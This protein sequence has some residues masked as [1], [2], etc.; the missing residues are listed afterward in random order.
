MLN[1]TLNSSLNNVSS[2]N[3]PH[4]NK[5]SVQHSIWA[6]FDSGASSNYLRPKDIKVV[7]ESTKSIG[8]TVTMPD[9]STSTSTEYVHLPLSAQLSKKAQK[10]YVIPKLESSTLIS[11]G[12]LCDD[13]CD[14]IFRKQSVHVINES[15]AIDKILEEKQSI[16]TGRRNN[17]NRL[18]DME[19]YPTQKTTL[20]PE[21]YNKPVIHPSIYPA[22]IVSNQVDPTFVPKSSRVP[23]FSSPFSAMNEI[24]EC[25]ECFSLVDQQLRTDRK[26]AIP[27][28]YENP[29]QSFNKLI[30]ENMVP[31]P[32]LN[33]IIRKDETKRDLAR[34]LHGSNCWPV[35]DTFIK[36][37]RKNHYNT[38]PGLDSKLILKHL[39]KSI[40]TEKGHIKQEFKGLQPTN[41]KLPNTPTRSNTNKITPDPAPSSSFL[42]PI[43]NI[44][45]LI[46][47]KTPSSL[48]S[49]PI[50]NDDNADLHPSSDSP[51]ISSNCTIYNIIE[52][53]P[54]GLGYT[55]LTGR[56]PYRSAQG[57]QYI[58]V[59]Y[60]YDAN[61]I[62][63]VPIK[64]REGPTIVAGW[65]KLHHLFATSGI[66]PTTYVQDNEISNCM[67]DAFTDNQVSFQLVPP[68]NHRAN[69]AERAIQ[70][71]K[72]H[73]I[74]ILTGI[75]PKFPIAQWDRLIPQAYMTL[76]LL[77]SARLN[78]NLSAHAFIHGEF[79]YNKT[80]LAPPGTKVVAHVKDSQRK[81]WSPHGEEMWYIGPALDHYRCITCYFP[82]THSERIVDTATFFPHD[83]PFPNVTLLDFLQQTAT[84][85]IYL[86]K[87]PPSTICPS[88]E[89][90]DP[91]FIALQKIGE[92]LHLAKD[93]L[94]PPP[95]PSDIKATSSIHKSSISPPPVP[96]PRVTLPRVTLPRVP[97]ITSPSN[98]NH[99][100]ITPAVPISSSLLPL[101]TKCNM[102]TPTTTH[103][104][105][106]RS[107]QNNQGT[108]FRHL[109]ARQLLAQQVFEHKINH[110]YDAKGNRQSLKH[111]LLG[112][113]K[114][115]WTQSLSNELGRLLKGNDAGV[116]H[117]DSIEFIHYDN[118]PSDKKVTYAN[119]VCDYRPLKSEVYRIRLVVG[120]D[121]LDYVHD[122]GSPTTN[123]LETKLLI[124]SVISDAH[125]GARF[126]S[127]DLKDFFL[128]TPM[129][130]PEYMRMHIK[131]L[132]TDIVRLYNVDPL[133]HN[134][135]VY[136]KIKKGVYGLK[137][138][139]ILAYNQL[140]GRLTSGGYR[141][142][143][144]STGM[145]EHTT[146]PTK[147][148]LCVD[149][150][151]I[152]YFAKNDAQHLL[153]T[154]GKTYKYSTDWTGSDFCGLHLQW[155]YSKGHVDISMPSYVQ[156]ALKRL[157]HVSPASPQYSPQHH[158]SVNYSN[159]SPQAA[160][161]MDTS[162]YL[163]PKSTRW[164]QSVVGT[165]LYY[166]RCVDPTI[167]TAINDISMSQSQPTVS[168][169]K[170]CTRLMDY[171]ATYPDAYIRYKASKMILSVDSD[172]SYLVLPKAC[173]R[174]AG[175][176]QLTD[177]KDAHTK[178]GPLL[179]ECKTIKHVVSSA[180]EAE[181]SALFHNAKTS[182]PIRRILIAL[183]HPQPP[184]PIKIDN[185]T[186]LGYVYNNIHQKRSKSWDMRFHW[187]R[188]KETQDLV[189]VYWK[190]G[191][192]NDADYFTKTH[193]TPY[194]RSQ[195]GKYVQDSMLNSIQ[196]P[197]TPQCP[198][199]PD[200][201]IQRG[202]VNPLDTYGI[203]T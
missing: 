59:A 38:W 184:T 97:I 62:H 174:I 187:L 45:K 90:G 203:Q 95:I 30:D 64:N 39:P 166:A 83:V 169:R 68:H 69:A 102:P 134:E 86:L 150:F 168:T 121:K 143:V 49:D 142:I 113:D 104:Y 76:N 108:S 101:N 188:D 126:F 31:S 125:K 167:S 180:A 194:H 100:T 72:A 123:L 80:P 35:R 109:A 60:N 53:S 51:N 127:A 130:E 103:R 13:N 24:I 40:A 176:F 36:A 152:K 112:P 42:D 145:F 117:T 131:H 156:K 27:T 87:H 74:T 135:Y 193:S 66:A 71:F 32:C 132:P 56:F 153:D 33:I 67:R 163:D 8:P 29:F 12:Q 186:A 28:E 149:D 139:A 110:I 116:S 34:F 158:N 11:V 55:D 75:D 138:A 50:I 185:S 91:T 162:P 61:S 57:N 3:P 170:Q 183:G 2:V 77:R 1:T 198:P 22:R 164:V 200:A 9:S 199:Y 20:Q 114:K 122:A 160:T 58:L 171:V 107:T 19:V 21:N 44:P 14:V 165:F 140:L 181:I 54:T 146:R 26:Y 154:L 106:L 4:H 17:L 179:V 192:D 177:G 120:G 178:N 201:R 195:R 202:C 148:C 47:D 99:T 18:W 10:A 118:V 161:A 88:L 141:P 7:K 6:T 115:I 128:A 94:P 175:F 43:A 82:K 81:T 155:N 98:H 159:K 78:P 48:S 84:D 15:R 196:A 96:S 79:N 147:F 111:L 133:I 157:Q 173:S 137:Q 93:F 63:A 189:L 65:K 124:N 23:S 41:G 46:A 136:C 92:A 191:T 73:F 197:L 119:F 105:N 5:S 144:G 85:L 182:I 89:A 151:G 52:N 172:A 37:I 25:N 16:L 190:K 70:T 129:D